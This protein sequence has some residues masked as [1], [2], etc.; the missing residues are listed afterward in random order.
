MAREMKPR[1]IFGVREGRGEKEFLKR[2]K[3]DFLKAKT[4]SDVF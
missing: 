1:S 2:Y 3:R 4:A